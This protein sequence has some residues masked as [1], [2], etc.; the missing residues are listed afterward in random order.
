[1]DLPSGSH[2]SDR[3]SQVPFKYSALLALVQVSNFPTR[4]LVIFPVNT[5]LKSL[6]FY[7]NTHYTLPLSFR[8]P[9]VAVSFVSGANCLRTVLQACH[10][11]YL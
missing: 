11:I 10:P 4:N 1:M 6:L 3:H 9:D 2:I 7:Q 5:P 8:E